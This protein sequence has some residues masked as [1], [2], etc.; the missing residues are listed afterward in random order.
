MTVD[1]CRRI[2][3]A[4]LALLQD[5]GIRIEHDTIRALLLSCGAAPGEAADD[6]R[7]PSE[8]VDDALA[9]APSEIHLADRSGA[10]KTLTPH[11]ESSIWSCPGM[12][13][14]RHGEH[15]PF[16]SGDM[17]DMARLLDQL[18]HVDVVFG[19]AMEDVPPKAGDVVGLNV[20]ARNTSKHIRV[21]CFTPEG[22]EAL[23]EMQP[24]VGDHPWF[25]IG[26][27]A[28]GPLR[29]THLALDIFKHSAGRGIPATLNGEPMAGV[30][31]PVT[32]AGS[33][34]V[35]NAEILAGLVINQL[36]EPGRP[37]IYNLGLAHILDMKTSIAVTGAPENALFAQWSGALGRFYSLPSGSWVSSEAMRPDAQAAL[38]KMF[39]WHTHMASGV[40]AIWGLGQL[41]SELTISPAQAVIDSE[42]IAY[43][44][45]YARGVAV[46]DEALALDVTRSV[47]IAGSFLGEMHTAEYF[48][49]EL[50]EPKVLFRKRRPDW[51]AEGA[52]RLEDRAE[53]VADELI[54]AEIDNGLT[55][56]QAKALDDI[57]SA[58]TERMT[59]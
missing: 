57:A 44:K 24:V 14:W 58:F 39:G 52:P 36:L 43:A 28:H 37:C 40:S 25:S 10:G 15:R 29:W 3:R 45:R 18:E 30:S 21:L 19:M 7:I 59:D 53:A 20:M 41:E 6:V 50:F 11:G 32:L 22:A 46:T 5:P 17:A 47:G 2:H 55:D 27:T 33:L 4:S 31:G 23:L 13:Y 38:E 48:R 16:R 49:T 12:G 51:A 34:A 54:A 8:M 56:D 26:F 9:Q 42:M 1:A 35:G